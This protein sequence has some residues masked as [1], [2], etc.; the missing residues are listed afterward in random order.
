M[1][2]PFTIVPAT[3]KSHSSVKSVK[4][5]ETFPPVLDDVPYWVVCMAKCS[6]GP[7]L[8]GAFLHGVHKGT[9]SMISQNL[10]DNIRRKISEMYP[11]AKRK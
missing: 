9:P 11:L 8:S 5:V 2:D 4:C 6:G 3:H 1:T 10:L 7:W